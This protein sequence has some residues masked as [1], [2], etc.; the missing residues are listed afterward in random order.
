MKQTKVL[1]STHISRKDDQ[2]LRAGR[3]DATPVG[4]E[5]ITEVQG[6][7]AGTRHKGRGEVKIE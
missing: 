7:H 5:R 6:G 1:Y 2:W 4:E 3:G